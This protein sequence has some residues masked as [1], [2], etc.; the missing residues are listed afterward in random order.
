M[1][2]RKNRLYFPIKFFE[3]FEGPIDETNFEL[4]VQD[5]PELKE[6]D[7]LLQNLIIGYD[8][9]QTAWFT[10]VPTPDF[11]REVIKPGEP[12]EA[13]GLGK[14]IES[15]DPNFPVGELVTG[16]ILWGD[17]TVGNATPRTPPGLPYQRVPAGVPPEFALSLFGLTGLTSWVGMMGI[18][19]PKA[20]EVVLVSTAA[21]AVGN[22]ACQLAKNAGAT[23]I[24]ITSTDE[25][26]QTLKDI[27]VDHT[28]NYKKDNIEQKI[29]EFAPN[30]LDLYFDNVGDYQ[31]QAALNTM[32]NFG[33][34][35]VCGQAATYR[36]GENTLKSQIT[37]FP[38]IMKNVTITGF[39]VSGYPH[40][41]EAAVKDMGAQ[42]AD[43][44]LKS[45]IDV[46]S[47]FENIPKVFG[48]LWRSENVG[49]LLLKLDV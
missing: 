26:C 16:H 32:K 34:I 35:V 9:S 10:R 49:K 30:G 12:M 5:V 27:G 13:M 2:Q 1:A 8:P 31:L 21:G 6:G 18:G 4:K 25:K 41:F 19:K 45:V 47:G 22:V 38:I 33:R 23:V 17:Y 7:F 43:G 29:R 15:K 48:S 36:T 24:G 42:I 11:Y 46:R 14:V 28:I 40:L 3:E 39:L 37:L 44:R 20:G